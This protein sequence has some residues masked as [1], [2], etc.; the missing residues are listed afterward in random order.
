MDIRTYIFNHRM[1]QTSFAEMVG[2]SKVL[3]GFW[4]TGKQPVG[5]KAAVK[6]EQLT[7]GEITRQELRHDWKEIWPE[8]EDK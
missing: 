1:N 4:V 2:V 7:N 3:V 5:V 8:L 6:L